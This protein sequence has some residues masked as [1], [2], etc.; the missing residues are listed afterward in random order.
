LIDTDNDG[1][2]TFAEYVDF[3]RK[4]LGLGIQPEIE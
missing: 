1:F 4:Y 2:I 3:I